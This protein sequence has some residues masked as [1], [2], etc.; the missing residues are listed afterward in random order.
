MTPYTI[1]E[2]LTQ[3]TARPAAGAIEVTE[4]TQ[5]YTVKMVVP[6]IAPEDIELTLVGRTLQVKAEATAEEQTGD[7]R[8]HVREY[9][10]SRVA[11]RI[12][13]PLPVDADAVTAHGANGIIT[14]RVPKSAAAQPKKIS[15]SPT[16]LIHG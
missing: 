13:F 1:A 2:L 8:K 10:V 9:A 16:P 12:E 4:D 11:R 7:I 14:I 15:V 5:G 3:Q 6:G